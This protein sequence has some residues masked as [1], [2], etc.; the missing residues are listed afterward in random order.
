MHNNGRF[1]FYGL[2]FNGSRSALHGGY[3]LA[4]AVFFNDALRAIQDLDPLN[5]LGIAIIY[6]VEHVFMYKSNTDV[7]LRHPCGCPQ[8]GRYRCPQWY[9]DG[10]PSVLRRQQLDSA[11]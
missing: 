2:D 3:V 5:N 7:L 1:H 6:I 4:Q 11:Q 8:H 10:Q 9:G